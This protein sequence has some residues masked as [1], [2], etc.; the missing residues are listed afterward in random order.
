M[1]LFYEIKLYRFFISIYLHLII[2]SPF[3]YSQGTQYMT[4]LYIKS[5][6]I[7]KEMIHTDGKDNIKHE[8]TQD[9]IIIND[10]LYI[11]NIENSFYGDEIKIKFEPNPQIHLNPFHIGFLVKIEDIF[12]EIQDK[13]LTVLTTSNYLNCSQET[14]WIEINETYSEEIKYCRNI[15]NFSEITL[16]VKIPFN[17][18]QNCFESCAKCSY[19]GNETNHNCIQCKNSQD[20][21]FKED[22]NSH[23]CFTNNTIDIGYF[24]DEENNIF[25]KCSIRC[26]ECSESADNCIKC[27][28]SKGFYSKENNINNI[29]YSQNEIE[30]DYYLDYNLNLFKK[31]NERCLSCNQS[32]NDS[33]TNCLRCTEDFHFDPNID[34]NCI[35]EDELPNINYY[36]DRND[37]KYKI[38]HESCLN[39]SGPN[40][41][42]CFLCNNTKGYYFKKEEV[43]QIC[44]SV[45]DIEQGYY[46]DLKDNLIEKCFERCLTCNQSGNNS[47]SNCLICN[48]EYHF[49]PIILNHCIKEDELPD[50]NYY[51]DNNDDTYKLC[52]ETCL[53][54]SGPNENNCK[55]CNYSKGYYL[56]EDDNENICYSINE[57]NGYYLDIDN[58]ILKKCNERCLSCT[59]QG[60][61]SYSFC[62]KCNSDFHF[63]PIIDYHC[64]REEELP[65]INYYIDKNDDKYKLCH[66]TCL[67]CSGPYEF[68]CTQCNNSKGYYFKEDDEIPKCHLKDN[69]E[70]GYYLDLSLNLIKKCNQR[71]LSCNQSGDNF[72]SN[73]IQCIN[74]SYHFDPIKS[75]HCIQK[76]ELQTIN[77][78]VDNFDN[79]Y[80][81]CHERCLECTGPN[82]TQCISCYNSR[83]YY[84]KEDDMNHLC[85]S[86]DEIEDGFYLNLTENLIKKCNERCL[87]CSQS[88]TD[89]YSNCIKC[90]NDDYH[91]HPT[92]NNHCIK[93]EELPGIN[94]YLDNITNKYKKCNNACKTC[95]GPYNNNCILCN[96]IGGYYYKENNESQICYSR[97]NIDIGYYLDNENNLFRHCNKRCLKCDE[98]GNDENTKC[99]KCNNSLAYHFDPLISGHCLAFDE[100][101]NINYYLDWTLD[102]FI[103]CHESC[104]TCNNPNNCITCN[105]SK[106][107]YFIENDNS[108]ICYTKSTISIKY[109]LNLTDNLFKLCNSRCYSCEI[110]GTNSE[111]N[112]IK[113]QGGSNYHFDPY[114][115]NHCIKSNELPNSSFY[116]ENSLDQYKICHESCLT[117]TGPFKNNC[118]SCNGRTFFNTEFFEN[119]CL[120][121]EEI[122]INYYSKSSSGKFTYHKC[123]ISCKTCLEG[124]INKCTSCDISEGYYPVEEKPGYC[125]TKSQIPIKYYFNQNELSIKKCDANCATC[126]KG[127]D[128]ITK[129]MNCDTCIPNTYFQNTTSTNCIP[130][131]ETKFY[132][133]IYNSHE[134]LFPCYPSCLT[135]E[136]GGDA[137]NNH[138]L[139]CIN[140]YYFD[141]E[142]P[143]NCVDDDTDCGIGCAKCYKNTTDPL[144]GVLSADKMCRRCSHKMGYYPLEKYSKNQFY[145]SCY[146]FN[147]SPPNYIFDEI[148]KY[149]TLCYKTCKYCYQV[150][151]S[152]NHSCSTCETDYI[153]IDEEPFNC[154]PTCKYYY[155]YNKYNQYKCTETKECPLEYPFLIANKSK[156]VDNCYSDDEFNLMFKNECFQR[157][158]EGTSSFIYRYNGEFTAKCVNSEEFLDDKEC[159]LDIKV[160]KLKYPEVTEDILTGYAEEYVHDYPVANSYVTSY[161]S[162]DSDTMNKYLIVLYKLEKCPKQKVEGFIPIGLDE[163]I[164]KVKTK[165]TIMQNVV[166]EVFYIIR[167]ST[168]PQINYYL[169]HPDTGE[170][171]DLSICSGAKLAIKTSIFDNGNVNED[172]VKYFSNL[173]VN[174][175]DI[176]DPFFNDICFIYDQEGKDVPLDDRVRLFYQNITLCED[177]CSYVGINLN[178]FEVEC[179]CDVKNDVQKEKDEDNIKNLLHNPLS[180]EVFG[181]LTNS[182]IEVLK[183]FKKAFNKKL[184]FKNYGGLMMVG[185]IIVQIIAAI[186]IKIQMKKVE[187]FI[188]TFVNEIKNPPKRK[189]NMMKFQNE[190]KS[191]NIDNDITNKASKDII[192]ND[193]TPKENIEPKKI[194]NI[195]NGKVKRDQKNQGKNKGHKIIESKSRNGDYKLIKQGSLAS[196]SSLLNI[197]DKYTLA[198]KGSLQYS[199]HYTNFIPKETDKNSNSPNKSGSEINININKSNNSSDSG[200]GDRGTTR[201]NSGASDTGLNNLGEFIEINSK[202]G[203]DEKN[204][205]K[206]VNLK[207]KSKNAGKHLDIIKIQKDPSRFKTNG[208]ILDNKNNINFENGKVIENGMSSGTNRDN[209]PINDLG[210]SDNKNIT[211]YPGRPQKNIFSIIQAIKSKK[212]IS[213][214]KRKSAEIKTGQDINILRKKIKKE[215]IDQLKEQKRQKLEKERIKRLTMVPYERKNYDEKQ[216]NE[217][218]YEDAVIYDKRNFCKMLW[219]SL[220]EKQT[221]INTFFS[222]NQLKPFSMKLLVL[223]FSFSCYF[224]INGFLYNEEYVSTKLESKGN[225]TF[226]EYLSDSIERILYTSIV[227]GIISFIIG[228]LF[229]TEKKIDDAIEKHNGNKILLKGEIAK[230]FRI[231]K[232]IMLC[233][234]IIQFI[235]MILFTIYIFCFCYV[236][237]NN[238][239]DWFESSLIVIG[240]IQIFSLFTCCLFTLIKYLGIK[241]QLEYCFKLTSFLE[242]NL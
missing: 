131:P 118:T 70:E 150:G 204:K 119:Q 165:N 123:H 139:S 110:G 53:N 42:E 2:L 239:L 125:L 132:I 58:N 168:P 235:L 105:N 85:Y 214:Q 49:D 147:K 213:K 99:L 237:P 198:K 179:S 182:N 127:Y 117:C 222:P 71:C 18:Y 209:I 89:L 207:D 121:L 145:V 161:L 177:G 220:K 73:C 116:L 32:G 23:N 218:D 141:D 20:Y 88:G 17:I 84:F 44:H 130:K 79:T 39:C 102:K 36:L 211:I 75:H 212:D 80:K 97:S 158:P 56:K 195:N 26:Q 135:C 223:I 242:D 50:I 11:V 140:E 148:K 115:L 154:F 221:L 100:L 54:C 78:Y 126:S 199:T 143:T 190:K 74:D 228:I 172:L 7:F 96:N 67:K 208:N 15:E 194:V 22:D 47:Y 77:Y 40:E 83:G 34:N 180:N 41:N 192:I 90:I 120:K 76:T 24:L 142:E 21:Y 205:K 189:T 183:C 144:Y 82:D 43:N 66:E 112:C 171:L 114:K 62:T 226:Y 128:N 91:F 103:K 108:G 166:V 178:T 92:I 45:N 201:I 241:F 129:E 196:T 137:D 159:E 104:S 210:F 229:N 8:Y 200:S 5:D 188:Y 27:N 155:Y 72:N 157:C 170:K 29:C 3:I 65:N 12:Y 35:K 156:C 169:Y 160:S 60:N 93:K 113:C 176:K 30:E 175:F 149:H 38:C 224:V 133:A 240:I 136:E 9:E 28:N 167:K 57:T 109:Y 63:D 215:I 37:N 146:P 94:Y 230:I 33:S 202:K 68:N 25:K 134:T 232:I 238:K 153:F 233:F 69:I 206:I 174:I 217:L 162:P 197:Q 95:Y 184:I 138:C 51:L 164:D 203:S 225:K 181:V 52:H 187:R 216:L 6:G 4:T 19:F 98:E 152:Q 31:C 234:I 48:N 111:S 59:S 219:Y 151:N 163:C 231:S 107:Y 173:G 64:I 106:G 55:L 227:G 10:C 81:L 124:G 87:S 13:E 193:I 236:Y 46:V 16:T 122:P 186:F 185:L 191:V 101:I 1:K 61:D 86:R 14:T